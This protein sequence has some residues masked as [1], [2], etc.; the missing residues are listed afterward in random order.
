MLPTGTSERGSGSWP[1]STAAAS[2][3]WV[4]NRGDFGNRFPNVGH[5]DFEP[6]PFRLRLFTCT[7]CEISNFLKRRDV[8]I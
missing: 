6:L 4:S 1:S 8:N 5:F 2:A 7:V 3:D